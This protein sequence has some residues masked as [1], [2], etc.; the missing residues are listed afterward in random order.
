M[1]DIH[2]VTVQFGG[3]KAL[4][5]LTVQLTAPVCGLIG[6]NGAG[7]TTLVN[8]LSGFARAKA[9]SVEVDGHS[10]LALSPVQ[11]V[12]FG[13]RRSFQTEQVVEDLSIWDNVLAILEQVDSDRANY[14]EKV[15]TVLHYTGLAEVAG[16]WGSQINL[17]QRRKLELAKALVG[18]PRVL[19][20][21]EP[22]AGINEQEA[23]Q[24]RDLIVGIHG[25]CGAQVLLIDHDVELIK[26]TC[27][28]TLVLDFGRL[29]AVGATLEVLNAPQ[30]RRAYLGT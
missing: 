6:P 17:F 11:R 2:A 26:G 28:Q 15:G 10:L 7:K 23:E 8:L 16:A 30:V 14:T 25:F 5:D 3:V 19:L 9:G 29:L 22:G 27:T 20:L 13:L 21:D 18:T 12:R 1:I 4:D 24:L